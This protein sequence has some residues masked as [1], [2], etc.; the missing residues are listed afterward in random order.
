MTFFSSTLLTGK[1]INPFNIFSVRPQPIPTAT[2]TRRAAPTTDGRSTTS[3]SD[4]HWE[5]ESSA[6]SIWPERRSPNTSWPSRCSSSHNCKRPPSNI[7][8]GGRSKSRVISDIQTFCV[9]SDTFMTRLA[10][11]SFWNSLPG[12]KCTRCWE[13]SP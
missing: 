1:N 10:C 9:F 3:T 5:R 4:V 6:T 11:I 7:N 13:S 8:S 12:E 2:I